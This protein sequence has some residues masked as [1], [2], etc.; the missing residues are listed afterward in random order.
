LTLFL[1]ACGQEE[2]EESGTNGTD[3]SQL[4]IV[5]TFY[6]MYEFTKQIVGEEA[7]VEM[8][9]HA[10]SDTH[11]YEPSAQ[12]MAKIHNANLLVYANPEMEIWVEDMLNSLEDSE[13]VPVMADAS[14]DL[15]ENEE[16]SVIEEENHEE[17]SHDHSEGDHHHIID[18]HTW[19]DPILAQEQVKEIMDAVIAAD[20]E[21][22]AFYLENGNAFLKELE[23]LHQLYT[24]ELAAAEN[25]QFLVQHA[26][27]G[28]IANRYNLDQYS[29]AG[30]STEA[31]ADPRAMVE[32]INFIAEENIPVL[33]YNSQ[34][35][36]QLA[37]TIAEEA[38]I[39]IEMLHSLESLTDE[40][41]E[42]G[43]DYI[44][45]MENNLEALKKSIR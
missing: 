23:D 39:E 37:E 26:A 29:L 7:E 5:T 24:E 32:A 17:A 18:P 27:F 9:V 33:Y 19:L 44:T 36:T 42:A 28:Y 30:L 16:Q 38:D 6:P 20:P 4:K 15:S 3:D 40:E 31:E 10:G 2:T 8:L 22:K 1:V 45:V 14:N 34:T 35:N 11:N 13:V 25:R 41:I 43:L 21:N 12:D